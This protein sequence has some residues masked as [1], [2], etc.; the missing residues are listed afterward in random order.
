MK[1]ICLFIL[2]ILLSICNS[3]QQDI[4]RIAFG[5][6]SKQFM[7]QPLW[8]HIERFDPDLWIWLGDAVYHDKQ[9]FPFDA[10]THGSAPT[11]EGMK[12]NYEAQ[13]RNADYKRLISKVPVIGV[14]DDHDYG[15][16]D[17]NHQFH[18]KDV[19][20]HLFLEFLNESQYSVRWNRTDGIYGAWN[21]N[22][23]KLKVILLDNRYSATSREL[24][25]DKQWKWLEEELS[26]SKAEITL[27]GTGLQFLPTDKIGDKF[28]NYHSY[29]RL[30]ALLQK[31][32]SSG[33]I[34]L[35]GDVHFAQ[36]YSLKPPC[37]PLGYPLYEFTSSGMTHCLS[38]QFKAMPW[39]V[40]HF[41]DLCCTTKSR[42]TDLYPDLNYGTIE[43]DWKNRAVTVAIHNEQGEVIP[44]F[45][46]T[47]ALD[48][49]QFQA[50]QSN[51][52]SS[53]SRDLC[54]PSQSIVHRVAPRMVAKMVLIAIT[55]IM[56]FLLSILVK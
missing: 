9:L 26:S 55:F 12:R 33:V 21:Y 14:W 51:T 11:T 43:I 39:M 18:L 17:G 44:N 53:E 32:K 8:K 16:D 45:R 42:E 41:I 34:F 31:T 13:L 27:L 29:D 52:A 1:F 54:A 10:I 20:R 25:G 50:T 28:H 4:T 46:F 49:L 56:I 47:L 37:S 35:S 3:E 2:P 30:M 6:C 7:E 40:K 38:S 24:L 23:N 5:S 19:N 15:V 22:Q 36:V 48:E